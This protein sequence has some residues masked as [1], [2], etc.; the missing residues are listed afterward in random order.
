MPRLIS[1]HAHLPSPAPLPPCS[2]CL[3]L[4]VVAYLASMQRERI[5][6]KYNIREPAVCCL[7]ACVL[8]SC[9]SCSLF[10]THVFLREHTGFMPSK[11]RQ[12]P[13]Q[14]QGLGPG[15][16]L[17]VEVYRALHTPPASAAGGSQPGTPSAT[18]GRLLQR[19]AGAMLL[20]FC[21]RSLQGGWGGMLQPEASG[22]MA[23]GLWVAGQAGA[24]LVLV[25][26]TLREVAHQR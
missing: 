26:L 9:Y 21:V 8:C 3:G 14:Q 12:Q 19:N 7:G 6:A 4:P 25:L 23:G 16:P 2:L 15:V 22:T 17:K 10:Q 24:A 18:R 13:P 5:A 1:T 11:P 20:I